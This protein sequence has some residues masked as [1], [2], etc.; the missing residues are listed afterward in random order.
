MNRYVAHSRN[1]NLFQRGALIFN[2]IAN[3]LSP[4]LLNY[5][6]YRPYK[7]NFKFEA[8]ESVFSFKT[9]AIRYVAHTF[10]NEHLL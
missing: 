3:K 2:S 10:S 7:S 5:L 6:L 1:T 8:A 9:I 4:Y